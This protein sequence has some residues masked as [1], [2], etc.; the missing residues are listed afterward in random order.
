MHQSTQL[1]TYSLILSNHHMLY[2]VNTIF[3]YFMC[4]YKAI[5]YKSNTSSIIHLAPLLEDS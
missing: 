3:G 4:V 2:K 1:C 5:V